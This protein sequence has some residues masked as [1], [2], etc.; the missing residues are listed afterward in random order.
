MSIQLFSNPFYN[1]WDGVTHLFAKQGMKED[2]AIQRLSQ[3]ALVNSLAREMQTGSDKTAKLL[4][5][6]SLATLAQK[7]G[8]G[9]EAL[10]VQCQAQ[11][12]IVEGRNKSLLETKVKASFLRVFPD[13]VSF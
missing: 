5:K 8:L 3:E 11:Q 12:E 13:A 2:K 4:Q 1:C 9:E 10:V 6:A 7:T